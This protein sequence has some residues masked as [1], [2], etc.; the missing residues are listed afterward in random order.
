MSRTDTPPTGEL[1]EILRPVS[2]ASDY[3]KVEL[4]YRQAETGSGMMTGPFTAGDQT[5]LHLKTCYSDALIDA[6]GRATKWQVVPEEEAMFQR[7]LDE[8]EVLP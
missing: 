4:I 2:V 6:E 7:F 8:V 5:Y 3:G 1:A